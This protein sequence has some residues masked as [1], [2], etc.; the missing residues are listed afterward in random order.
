LEDIEMDEPREYPIPLTHWDEFCAR[1]EKLNR[2]AAKLGCEPVT[3]TV[4]GTRKV[5]RRHYW[6][7][8]GVERSRGYMV[9]ARVVTLAGSAPKLEGHQFI[10][11]VEPL[12]DGKS[13]LFHTVPGCDVKVDE[14][15]RTLGS[16]VCEHCN[17]IRRRAETF[18]VREIETGEQKQVGRNCLADFTGINTPEKIAG[19]TKWLYDFSG[20]AAEIDGYWGGPGGFFE[21]TIDTMEVLA[22]TSAAITLWGWVPK[23]QEMSG[24]GTST[25]TMVGMA[26]RKTTEAEERLVGKMKAAVRENSL[27]AEQ[28][29]K[30]VDWIKTDLSLRAKS[31]YEMNLVTLTVNDLT[32]RKHLG[33]V[34][35]AVSAYLRAMNQEYAKK[36]AALAEST[37]VG[38]PKERLRDVDATIESMRMMESAWG[39]STMIK[40]LDGSGNLMTWF[41]SGNFPG[42]EP[43]AKVKLT[44]TVKKHSE[45][46]GVKE[47]QLSRCD[48]TRV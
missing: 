16:S 32:Q 31:D 24:E 46:R 3:V 44:G 47:T 14:R 35:S 4:I 21:S 33:I 22:L 6:K 1:M 34:C 29:A 8:D 23:S 10:A 42:L 41:A 40:F 28:A 45:Y 38:K 18:V 27:H 9:D 12:S 17:K 2:R 36:T 20:M 26:F 43:G 37:W 19:M 48:V 30:V 15:I 39:A 7:V 25:A 11:K 5:E 13:V